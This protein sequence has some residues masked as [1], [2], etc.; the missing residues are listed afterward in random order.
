MPRPWS[1]E[2]VRLGAILV[3]AWLI[4][5]I[6]DRPGVFLF[7]GLLTYLLWHLHHLYRL[8]K[9]LRE[10]RTY[11]PPEANGIWGEVFHLLYG[12]RRRERARK[13][14]L[15][16]IL[17]QFKE[18]TSA[19]PDATVVLGPGDEI[20]WFNDAARQLIKLHAGQDVGQ[21]IDN[22]IRDPEFG[23]F[24]ERGNESGYILIP[25][26][27]DPAMT[28]S[29]RVVPYGRDL[30]LLI[31]RDVSQQQRL[32]QMRR[33]FVANVSHELRTPLTVV[34]GFLETMIDADDECTREWNRSLVLMQQQASR[35]QHLV[36]DLL[37]L[38]RLETDSSRPPD[39]PVAVPTLIATICEDVEH[40]AVQKD[41]QVS[42][43]AEADLGLYG[44]ERELHSAFANLVTNAIRYTP[45][46]GRI[47]IRWWSDKEGA[48]YSVSDTG[49]GIEA[50]H[51]PRLTERFYRV[52]VGRS[53]DS[54]GTGLGLAIVKHVLNR[55]EARLRIDSVPGR[56]STFTCDFPLSRI[57]RTR[58]DSVRRP[59]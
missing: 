49:V 38:S 3:G 20:Q 53:R 47:H 23:N 27:K 41:Q 10:G 11:Y 55:Y 37:L 44:A 4:G 14:R 25:A 5:V 54:G 42:V 51:I 45:A 6:L 59:G 2:F 1:A 50:V 17:G 8:E 33:D 34:S 7:L 30:R 46:E 13:R 22:L 31:L 39:E 28:L 52:D 48:H 58:I 32:E 57:C 40:L 35:M 15:A 26:P 16:A 9:W 21:R 56:G 19:M 12:K 29:V 24:L 36:E 18:A 43:D